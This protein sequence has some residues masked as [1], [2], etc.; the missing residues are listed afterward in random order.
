[1]INPVREAY[2]DPSRDAEQ[3]DSFIHGMMQ[4]SREPSVTRGEMR[5]R[6]RSGFWPDTRRRI[7]THRRIFRQVR[8]GPTRR[9]SFFHCQ[10]YLRAPAFRVDSTTR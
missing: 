1:M 4:A 6:F 3:A 9:P 8:P 5:R 7:W 10:R 2:L